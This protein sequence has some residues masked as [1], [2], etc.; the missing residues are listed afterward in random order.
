MIALRSR[1]RPFEVTGR[2]VLACFIG[3]F[4]TVGAVNA[5]MIRFAV[6]TFGGVETQSSY[7]AG[8]AFKAETAASI[9]Q[10]ARGW[11]VDVRIE[12]TGEGVA[13]NVAVRDAAGL[14]VP[15]LV[16]DVS[17]THP[18]DRRRDVAMGVS[19]QSAGVFRATAQGAAGHRT[20][21]IELTR[22]GERMFR[23]VERI[24]AP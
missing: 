20:L 3:F 23:S 15:N 8:L 21:V 6:T 9:A 17:L 12:P 19:E 5:V 16:A 11:K 2:F 10:A 1:Q 7:K 22:N 24:L 4:L 18:A 13:V 14:A